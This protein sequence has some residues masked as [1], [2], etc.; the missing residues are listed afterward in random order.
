MDQRRHRS[1]RKAILKAH[2]HVNK[3]TDQRVQHRQT[4]LL[5]EFATHL[6]T[7]KFHTAFFNRGIGA[8][9]RGHD[10]VAE[11]RTGR[12]G[13]RR[14]A[15]EDIPSRTEVLHLDVAEARLLQH[16]ADTAQLDGIRVGHLDQC[17]AGEIDTETQTAREQ[18]NQRYQYQDERE[19][20]GQ[21]ALAHEID[22]RTFIQYMHETSQ[23]ISASAASD[24]CRKPSLS[25]HEYP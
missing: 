10:I 14:D 15:D 13:T 11:L 19:A 7:D 18:H 12:I 2:R 8:L 25:P 4:A 23:V 20:H 1:Q 16:I 3:N 6:R 9:Q 21:L 24:A 22:V 17:A 5:G